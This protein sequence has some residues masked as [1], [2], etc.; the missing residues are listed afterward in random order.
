MKKAKGLSEL[1]DMMDSKRVLELTDV[2]KVCKSGKNIA[3]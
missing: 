2:K 3:L 1:T